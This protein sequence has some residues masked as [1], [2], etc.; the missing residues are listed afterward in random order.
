MPR[1]RA[2]AVCV[3]AWSAV[4]VV[5]LGVPAAA[6]MVTGTV[7]SLGAPV[8]GAT[9][10]L[11]E[12]DRTL[13]TGA[14]GRFTFTD[15]PHGTYTVFAGVY[16]YASALDTVHVT[17]DTTR[18]SFDLKP[19][20]IPLEAIVVTASPE[21]RPATNAYESAASKSEVDFMN[22]AG[23]SFAE[24]LSD[25]PGV[26]ARLNGSAPARPILR[27]LGDNEVLVLE[28]G[29]R[30]GDISAFDPAHATPLEAVA[31]SQVDVVRGPA[32]I[33]YGPNTLGGV[34]NV[35]TD[36]VPDIADR[37]VSGT[38]VVET[39]SVS[40]QYAGYVDNVLSSNHS[41]LRVSAGGVNAQDVGIP[42]GTY[43]DPA[44]GM[45]FALGQMPHT[46]DRSSEGGAG[47]T[48][49]GGFGLIGLGAEYYTA[50]Y[51]IPGVPP[52]PNWLTAP[53]T[54]SQII[55]DRTTLELRARLNADGS[56]AKQWR[57]DATYNDYGHSEFPT[58]EDSSGVS[59]SEA[60]HF[61]KRE[62][63]ATLELEHAPRGHFDGTLG[64]W[65]DIADLAIEGQ[66]PLGPNSLT[67]GVAVFA[68]EEYHVG[69]THFELGVRAD[70]NEIQTRPYPQSGDSVFRTINAS[71]LADAVTASL[72]AMH[73][74]T[75]EL[76]G[77]VS[78]AR[79]FRAPT[80]QELFANGLDASSE[81]YS[82]GSATLGPETGLGI[83]GS[84]K[85]R[86]RTAQ[87]ELSPYYNVI[88]HYI[89]AF[90]TRDTI[91]GFPVRQFAAT[92]ARLVGAEA[93]VTVE[94]LR[95][96]ALRASGDFVNAEDIDQNMPLPFTPP[97]RGL[98]RGT[99]QTGRW[100][101]ILEWRM[102]AAQNRLG[103]GDTPTAGYAV[104]NFGIGAR[105]VERTLVH[106][107][108][109]HCDNLFNTV[110]R[111]NLSVVKDFLPEPG[112]GVRLDYEMS[113]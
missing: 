57:L 55:Q 52:N 47:Y 40:D 61:H 15:V 48:Y 62:F 14:D 32:A 60:N 107:I 83:D 18:L 101:G 98:L 13:R 91:Q 81:T 80:V 64:L 16:G 4:S 78:F 54:T 2:R 108:S 42:S 96:L 74:F 31:V 43:V 112:R 69:R 33:L 11:L 22:S 82:I 77:S 86:Y 49:Q 36:I 56:F 24:K 75:P 39:N 111:D 79:S 23:A 95:R 3:G 46:F 102:A 25:I 109:L 97:L 59:A 19:S 35:I 63:N 72:G 66:Q 1:R 103:V 100:V 45:R 76:T 28:N 12:L 6:Q 58:L 87:F 20:P 104:L 5:M 9:V 53:P 8:V 90:L 94:P 68:Y 113:Y 7:R 44:S 99:Y 65:T 29:L 84:L 27:G 41:A 85:G 89:Y 110:Y 21:P 67:T 73:Q 10:R 51:G 71:R 88:D 50:D 92:R 30:T 106:H 70:Y 105:F 17:R 93:A 38:G 26:A 34:V 37:R